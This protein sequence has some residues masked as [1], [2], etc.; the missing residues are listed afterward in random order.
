M[1]GIEQ[2]LEALAEKEYLT[3]SLPEDYYIQQR[4]RIARE[5]EDKQ[6]ELEACDRVIRAIQKSRTNKQQS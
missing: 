4:E 6:K 3:D 2:N 1:T 5:L